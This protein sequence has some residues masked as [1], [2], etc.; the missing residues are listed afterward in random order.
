MAYR[1]QGALVER[2]NTTNTSGA[3]LTLV[4]SS[5]SY[6]RFTGTTTHIVVLPV[7]TTIPIGG[8]FAVLN[9]STG[10]VTVNY[11]GGSLAATVNGD[12][13]T[14]FRCTDNSTAAGAWDAT[15]ESSSSGSVTLTSAEKLGAL[16]ALA[17]SF[18]Q[19]SQ[20]DAVTLQINPEEIGGNFW[21]AKTS[22]ASVA[23]GYHSSFSVDGYGFAHGGYDGT[24]TYALLDR[25]NDDANSWLSRQPST[26]A[27]F[28]QATFEIGGFG[29]A[30]GG[31]I[32]TTATTEKHNHTT[33]TWSTVASLAVATF[34][35]AGFSLG[36]YGYAVAGNTGADT[37]VSNAYDA[38]ANAWYI[39]APLPAAR[40]A[41]G[42][43][44]LNDSGFVYGGNVGSGE[45]Y[46]Y[47]QVTN[48]WS[49]TGSTTQKEGTSSGNVNSLI[50]AAG[51]NTGSLTAEVR[52]YSD[53]SQTWKTITPL[54]T[55]TA[56]ASHNMMVINGSGIIS[57]GDTGA[58]I[59]SVQEYVNTSF[60]AV[61][62]SKKSTS[63][64]TSI[65]VAAA[66]SG[67]VTS[68]PVRIRTDGTNWKNLTANADSVLKQ[69]ETFAKFAANGS[70]H[71]NYEL[72]IGLPTYLAAVGSGQWTTIASPG[73]FKPANIGGVMYTFNQSNSAKYSEDLN[74]WAAIENTASGGGNFTSV[75]LQGL[76]YAQSYNGSN[77]VTSIRRYDPMTNVYA[78]MTSPNTNHYDH[79]SSQLNGFMYATTGFTGSYVLAHEYFS[80]STNAWTNR[81]NSPTGRDQCGGCSFNGFSYIVNGSNSGSPQAAVYKY[82]DGGNVWITLT[83]IPTAQ[84]GAGVFVA[85]GLLSALGGNV[86]GTL[87]Q[88]YNDSS[89]SWNLGQ[90]MPGGLN[91][92][93]RSDASLSGG[94]I[95]SNQSGPAYKFSPSIKNVVLGA[96]LR[97]S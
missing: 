57:G 73:T 93:G 25:F 10:I 36:G 72:Q 75:S 97:I 85:D 24:T 82:N 89:N 50:I 46:K 12:S 38:V 80:P 58:Y 65:F 59:A 90:A 64:P 29:Y 78:T 56:G 96:A 13:Q 17:G 16:S 66:L 2:V 28:D 1:K 20:T 39:R 52:E 47:N 94:G 74:N 55:A 86:S 8:K 11:N 92:N 19:D 88:R 91:D 6:Q 42:S 77:F 40:A 18:Y 43:A 81:L 7:G 76:G 62:L 15:I 60:F 48:S 21:R 44:S 14:I 79:L 4:A 53:V 23:R 30:A 84:F 61:P 49:T 41:P 70:G 71:Y 27:R 83:S 37:A 22:F 67:V 54:A 45:S 31:R 34:K 69:G 87:N 95:A 3:T 63:A 35:I 5:A 26:I 32:A 51:G 9:R 68:V 33:N